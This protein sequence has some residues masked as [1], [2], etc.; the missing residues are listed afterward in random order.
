M[1]GLTLGTVTGYILG[2]LILF[3][4]AKIFFT[5]FKRILKLLINSVLGAAILAIINLL[6]LN[7]HIG[8]NAIS[9][10]IVG[11]LGIPG[12]CLLMLLQIFF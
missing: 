4:T 9:C 6:P 5:P 2:L 7:I 10:L 8:I 3:V 11:I 1:T 12:L